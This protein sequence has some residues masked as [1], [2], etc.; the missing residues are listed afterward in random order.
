LSESASAIA[1]LKAGLVGGSFFGLAVGALNFALLEASKGSVLAVLQATYST[2]S[3]ATAAQTCFSNA[4]TVGIPFDV[5]LP[6]GVVA[7]L[8][9]T[10]YGMYFEYLPGGGYRARAAAVAILMLLLLLLFGLAGISVNETTRAI[11]NGLDSGVMIAFALIIASLYRRFTREVRFETPNREKLTIKVDGRDF[12]EKTRT[13][14]IHSSHKIK[15]PSGGGGFH[16]WLV[17][18]GVSVLDPKSP[19]TTM[20]VD[21]D[22]LLKIS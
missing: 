3:S 4:V 8:F 17:S 20:K 16:S 15:A 10:L 5:I 18:G 21:G 19:E 22:G 13:L 2:C 14:S 7:I 9:G 11:M 1:G 6:A 12:T